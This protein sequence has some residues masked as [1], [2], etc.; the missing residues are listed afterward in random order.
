MTKH[1]SMPAVSFDNLAIKYGANNIINALVRFVAKITNPQ[2]SRQQIAMAGMQIH[3]PMTSMRVFHRICISNP[4]HHEYSEMP[5]LLDA[6]HM[7]PTQVD[8]R[9]QTTAGRFNTVLVDIGGG[10]SSDVS[11]A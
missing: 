3:L 5:N 10:L 9:G 7:R 11:G 4:T 8:S 6:V 2:L 1:P